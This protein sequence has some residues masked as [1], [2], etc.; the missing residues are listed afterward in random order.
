MAEHYA[1]VIKQAS[2]MW[3]AQSPEA[4][5]LLVTRNLPSLRFMLA[6]LPQGTAPADAA[7]TYRDLLWNGGKAISTWLAATER[8][9]LCQVQSGL[10][11]SWL[12]GRAALIHTLLRMLGLAVTD[13]TLTSLTGDMTTCAAA[14]NQHCCNDP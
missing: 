14:G 2:A 11:Q 6:W 13:R 9:S 12:W 4:A 10:G 5:L 3:E 7:D 8:I 1:E